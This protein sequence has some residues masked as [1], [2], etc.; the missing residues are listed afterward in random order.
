MRRSVVETALALATGEI[1][2]GAVSAP[3]AASDASGEGAADATPSHGSRGRPDAVVHLQAALTGLATLHGAADDAIRTAVT[4]ILR[5]V[6]APSVTDVSAPAAAPVQRNTLVVGAPLL[7][8]GPPGWVAYAVLGIAS[9]GIMGYA[10][11][12]AA[13][14]RAR[15][16]DRAEPRVIPRT[17][18]PQHRGRIQVQG[19]GLELAFP[20]TRPVPMTK[21]EGLAGLASL[22][23]MLSRG[24]LAVR[25]QAFVAAA[26]FINATLHMCPPDLK[27]T[28]RNAAIREQRGDERVDIEIHTGAA[29]A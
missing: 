5:Q 3:K 25:D 28:F 6:G 4:P 24:E 20:W 29:F 7:A 14:S 18:S 23:G 9:V 21:A 15:S 2:D 11:Y 27:R 8:G 22:Q 10:A 1:E 19:G 13:Q 17:A 16:R 12:Q 26:K